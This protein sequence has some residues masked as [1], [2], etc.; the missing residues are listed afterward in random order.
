MVRGR[1]VGS[2][3]GGGTCPAAAGRAG[4]LRA[5]RGHPRIGGDGARGGATPYATPS[6]GTLSLWAPVPGKSSA[7]LPLGDLPW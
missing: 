6:R 7:R 2:D 1:T 4:S 3:G 5:L